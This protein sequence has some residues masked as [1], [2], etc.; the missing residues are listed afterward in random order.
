MFEKL[1]TPRSDELR[2]YGILPS[3]IEAYYRLIDGL[4]VIDLDYLET[5]ID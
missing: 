2:A 3:D 1:A 5:F 4:P